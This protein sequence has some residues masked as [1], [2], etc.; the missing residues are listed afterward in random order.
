MYN[1]V[2]TVEGASGSTVTGTVTEVTGSGQI[3]EVKDGNV[4]YERCPITGRFY[5]K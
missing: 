4:T 3:L 2:R 1:T 5:A